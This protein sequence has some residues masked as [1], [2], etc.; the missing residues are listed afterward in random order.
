[1][2]GNATNDAIAD[3]TIAATIATADVTTGHAEHPRAQHGSAAGNNPRVAG[4]RARS[5]DPGAL[6]RARSLTP[7]DRSG[8]RS[9][10]GADIPVSPE[11]PPAEAWHDDKPGPSSSLE[12]VRFWT[13]REVSKIQETARFVG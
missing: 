3:A 4:G 7:R 2:S 13:V 6:R 12:D 8:S 5:H 11:S 10:R 1:M 9:P